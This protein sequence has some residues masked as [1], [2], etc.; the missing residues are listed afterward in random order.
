VRHRDVG[1]ALS[2]NLVTFLVFYEL[3]TLA[4]YPL[5]AHRGTPEAIAGARTYLLYTLTGGVVL[6]VGVVWLTT[7]SGRWSSPTAG[8]RSSPACRRAPGIAHAVFVLLIA[9]SP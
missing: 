9:G 6:L 8:H 1:I 4:T 2:G 3:L 5:V 7:W